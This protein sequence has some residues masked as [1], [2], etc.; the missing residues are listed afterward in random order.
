MAI[1]RA[2]VNTG[3]VLDDQLKLA[4]SNEQNVYTIFHSVD[5]ALIYSKEILTDKREIEI[6]IYDFAEKVLY[7]LT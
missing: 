1:L 6:V 4:S 7:L 3:H 2:D 5:L